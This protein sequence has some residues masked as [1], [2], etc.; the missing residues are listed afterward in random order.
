M[1]TIK[2]DNLIIGDHTHPLTIISGPCVI[3]NKEHA[4]SCAKQ[5]KQMFSP[6]PFQYIFK[7]S[8]DK[9]NRSSIESFRGP[10]LKEGLEIL[11]AIKK[12][13][14]LPILTDIHTPEQAELASQV[15]DIIQIPAFLCRQTDLLVAAGKTGKIV[16]IKKGQFVAPHDMKN[17]IDKILSTGND[18]ILLTERGTMFGY[19]NL[20]VDMR[21]FPI[22]N[23]LG[24]P[25]CM[26]ASHSIQLPGGLG[27]IS[28]G[29]REFIPT[30]T[31]A[32]IAS[33][34]NALFIESHPCPSKA[35]CD[36]ASV[37]DFKD[38]QKLL[39]ELDLLYPIMQKIYVNG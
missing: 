33:G 13:L 30:L 16:N 31:K 5:L 1:K 4:M 18:K 26:D 23:S 39:K 32:A 17:A 21:S 2:Q 11:Q 20:V 25:T 29:N 14:N 34:C 10:G 15:C 19:N 38:L 35:L 8:F 3:E 27:N 37:M 12:E 36:S 22:M 24:F 6:Y 7:A 28:G 9:A